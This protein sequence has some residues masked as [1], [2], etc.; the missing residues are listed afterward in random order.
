MVSMPTLELI[1]AYLTRSYHAIV[2][3]VELLGYSAIWFGLLA[4]LV[5]G[6][7]AVDAARQ[8]A[9]EVRTTLWLYLTHILIFGPIVAMLVAM[10]QA[11]LRHHSIALIDARLWTALGAP[12]TMVLTVCVGDVVGY[13]R[14]R[15]QHTRWLWPAHV[16]H[17]SDTQMT[18]VTLN[19]FHPIDTL[20]TDCAEFGCLAAIGFP[21]WALVGHAV[22]KTFYGE[23]VHADFPWTYGPLG[24]ILVSPAMH[25]WHHARDVE[26]AGSNFATV[27]SV[28]D[29]I[30]GTYFVPGPCDV[31]LGV[32]DYIRPTTLGRLIHPLRCWFFDEERDSE[33][34]VEPTA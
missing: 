14:H 23:F 2:Q 17:H 33:Q 20:L 5:K 11:A 31:P 8:A 25:R 9:G 21:Q 24:W 7:D 6:K 27:F 1:N 32:T 10:L 18:W 12:T 30:F 4:G 19:R 13:W 28:H 15:L 26:G 34:R 22:A 29:R 16:I 3:A